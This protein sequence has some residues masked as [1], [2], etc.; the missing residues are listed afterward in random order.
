MNGSMAS[1]KGF[2]AFGVYNA[3]KAAI[4]SFARTWTVDLKARHIRVN[5]LS[6]G[7]IDT[8]IFDGVP[9]RRRTPSSP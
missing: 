8:G 4:R 7:T 1:V 3:S 9:R 6:P 2:A 5:V